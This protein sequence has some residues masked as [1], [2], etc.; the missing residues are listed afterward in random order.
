MEEILLHVIK[1]LVEIV[2]KVVPEEFLKEKI[3][4]FRE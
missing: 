2:G 4:H 1:M 3:F